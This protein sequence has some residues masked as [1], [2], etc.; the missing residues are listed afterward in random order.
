MISVTGANGL[1]GS[2]IVRLLHE[3]NQPFVALK[4]NNSDISHL[5]DLKHYIIWRDADITND[6]SLT[7]ALTDVTGIIHTAGM[8]SFNPR[9][10]EKVFRTNT[11]GTQNVVN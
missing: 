6:L 5:N 1:L 2:Y 8:V 9:N 7:E 3:R 10:A 11:F 4:R